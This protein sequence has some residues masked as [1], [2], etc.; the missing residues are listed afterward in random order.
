MVSLAAG[1]GRQHLAAWEESWG[2]FGDQQDDSKG[3]GERSCAAAAPGAVSGW[4]QV[5]GHS[6]TC[7]VC[8]PRD[9]EAPCSSCCHMHV[10]SSKSSQPVVCVE[11]TFYL[12]SIGLCCFISCSVLGDQGLF[13]SQTF[14]KC[15]WVTGAG[16]LAQAGVFFPVQCLW[17]F[18]CIPLPLPSTC[19]LVF[20][21]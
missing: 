11:G 18:S 20:I 8:A 13:L 21:Y 7:F 9:T 5:R 6:L 10:F 1:L 16:S 12:V 2:R 17:L 15:F 3:T 14:I 4:V 19:C